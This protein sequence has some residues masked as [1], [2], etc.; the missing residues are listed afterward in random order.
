MSDFG[1]P[2]SDP[3]NETRP[4]LQAPEDSEGKRS[5]FAFTPKQLGERIYDSKD[6]KILGAMGG[7]E[8][9]ALGLRTDV[10]KGLWPN[11][12][13]L[14]GQITLEDVWHTLD[15]RL[16]ERFERNLDVASIVDQH[17]SPYGIESSS[18]RYRRGDEDF[19]QAKSGR[20]GQSFRH[21][22]EVFGENKIPIRPPKS[23]VQLMWQALHDKTLVYSLL[24]R[25][26]T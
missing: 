9:L 3:S 21:R 17:T 1:D 7:L 25:V 8:G 2:S 18:G 11:E 15:G 24:F 23:I 26:L 13:I 4:L 10:N 12:D 5:P 6:L 16:P 19:S 22:R 14:D 20:H